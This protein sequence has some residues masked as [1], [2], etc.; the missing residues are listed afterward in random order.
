MS[1]EDF[2]MHI[3]HYTFK[4]HKKES[5]TGITFTIGDA[6][7]Y[8]LELYVPIP[9]KTD[10]R[11][12]YIAKTAIL[13][14]IESLIHCSLKDISK[15]YMEK[16]SMGKELLIVVNHIL[17]KDYPYILYVSFDDKSQM[18]CNREHGDQLDL[19]TYSIALNGYTWYEMN[20]NAYF[21]P[22]NKYDTYR[23]QV[24]LYMSK[25]RK[26]SIDYDEFYINIEKS[27]NV[28]AIDFFKDYKVILINLYNNSVT[29]PE[30]FKCLG[31]LVL[32]KDKCKL[33]KV[34]LAKFIDNQ[35]DFSR[36]WQYDIDKIPLIKVGGRYRS[37]TYKML[38]N[39]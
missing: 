11:I 12:E 17:K 37:K 32:R 8:C 20:L 15:D 1:M 13:H 38:K 6:P 21:L 28:F 34:W 2:D 29:F 25:E 22:K 36:S 5:H 31:K 26:E 30:F 10:K 18:P 7:M 39:I 9:E 23:E 27:G 33:F 4:L 35:I 14:K 19:M 16:Y 24:K 3:S